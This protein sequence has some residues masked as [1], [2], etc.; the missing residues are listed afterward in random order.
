[1]IYWFVS[2]AERS[3]ITK[4][5]WAHPLSIMEIHYA[6]TRWSIASGP[7]C[8][9]VQLAHPKWPVYV[10][11]YKSLTHTPNP[12]CAPVWL[13]LL[14]ISQFHNNANELWVSQF[15]C[16]TCGLG[17][18]QPNPDAEMNM[19]NKAWCLSL[20]PALTWS[21]LLHLVCRCKWMNEVPR[22][23]NRFP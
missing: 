7:N 16:G 13:F 8:T 12:Y 5:H 15:L 2:L 18:W 3:W 1:M 10:L 9:L 14:L 20:V 23:R 11:F 4:N 6:E 21:T 19:H 22:R 17:F